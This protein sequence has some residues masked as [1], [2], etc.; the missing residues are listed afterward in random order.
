MNFI[1]FILLVAVF[2][3]Y[4]LFIL[5]FLPIR[6][7]YSRKKGTN[8]SEN[9]TTKDNNISSV[10]TDKKNQLKKAFL[11]YLNGYIRYFIH[12]TAYIPFRSVRDFIYRNVLMA[13][14]APKVIL[15]FGAE[16][17]APYNLHIGEGTIIGDKAVMDARNGIEI[18]RNVNFSSN[19][20]IWTEQHDHRDPYFSVISNES[21]RVKIGDRA[22]IGPNVTILHSVTIGEGA[23]IGAGSV[24]TKDV[25]PFSIYAG[26]PAKKI[27]ER[28][29]DLRYEFDGKG[30]P[31]Y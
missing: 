11:R 21:Y 22:W 1:V 15:Y 18:G 20:S 14:M 28:T 24:V 3:K 12:Q 23:V 13:D 27:G 25:P 7:Y 8:T 26:I 10:S 2:F 19:V 5:S 16:I 4:I 30:L 29:H 6:F 17:R 9:E 31:F